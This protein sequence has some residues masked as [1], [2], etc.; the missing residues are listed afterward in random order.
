MMTQNLFTFKVI[1]RFQKQLQEWHKVDRQLMEKESR[2]LAGEFLDEE[3]IAFIPNHLEFGC[4]EGVLIY[5]VTTTFFQSYVV[6][7]AP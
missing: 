2:L 4:Y 1:N 3:P 7:R 5:P 6:I